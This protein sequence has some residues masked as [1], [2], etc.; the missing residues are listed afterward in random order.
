[1]TR[2]IDIQLHLSGDHTLTADD[3]RGVGKLTL[4]LS[5]Q[6]LHE[7]SQTAHHASLQVKGYE[8][9][10]VKADDVQVGDR[11]LSLCGAEVL[12]A[13]YSFAT[14]RFVI[15]LQGDIR[16]SMTPGSEVRVIRLIQ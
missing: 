4:P 10:R 8:E 2:N 3:V 9:L 11:L 6:Q 16:L 12:D 5:T 15:D 1:M 14:E 13:E 7:L